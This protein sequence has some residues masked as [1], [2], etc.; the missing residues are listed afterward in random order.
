MANRVVEEAIVIAD[1]V[2]E[3]DPEAVAALLVK[4]NAA[5]QLRNGDLAVETVGAM[6]D[7]S[8]G[9]GSWHVVDG[10]TVR[11]R[12]SLSQEVIDAGGVCVATATPTHTLAHLETNC[13]E[14]ES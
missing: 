10:E 3:R 13:I 9:G 8:V 11:L 6:G 12:D 7:A 2:L 4:A 1:R 14:L 5:L